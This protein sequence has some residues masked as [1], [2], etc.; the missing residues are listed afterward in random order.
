MTRCN[1]LA[2]TWDDI[3]DDTWNDTWEDTWCDTWDGTWGDQQITI[4]T[5]S[6]NFS[7][8]KI[9]TTTTY[10]FCYI[11]LNLKCDYNDNLNN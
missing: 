9:N 3:W 1:S 7:D 6:D 11:T 8:D 4:R 2:D 5:Q 10:F